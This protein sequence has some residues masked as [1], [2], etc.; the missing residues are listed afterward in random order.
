MCVESRHAS[1]LAAFAASF[2]KNFRFFKYHHASPDAE[3]YA[4]IYLRLRALG[5]SQAQMNG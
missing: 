3:T 2:R 1:S 5:V 4:E